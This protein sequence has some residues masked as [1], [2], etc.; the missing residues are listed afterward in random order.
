MP[1]Y[2]LGSTAPQLPPSGRY[3]VAPDANIV[4]DVVLGEDVSVWFGATLR[5]DDAR[6]TVGD[7]T[8]IQDGTIIHVEDALPA[9][10]GAD[11]V[12]GHKVILHGCTVGDGSLVG[13]GAVLL[14]GCRIGRGCLVGANALVTEGKE[15]PDYSLIIGSPARAVRTVGPDIE[16][17]I[18]VGVTHYV[19]RWRTFADQLTRL[20]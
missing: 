15:F 18:R 20:D 17:K 10:V 1:I 3:W 13:M 12:V 19:E 5:G 2:R 14:D 16:A 7:R 8:N 11:V 9:T 6:I 4:G